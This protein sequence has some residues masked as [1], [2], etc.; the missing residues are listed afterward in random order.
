MSN[1]KQNT[2]DLQSI[3]DAVNNLPEAIDTS[4]A[5]ASA[6]EIIKNETAYVNGEKITGTIEIFDGSYECS[7]E[8]T[9]GSIS[10]VCPSLSI[11]YN[12]SK[13][14]YAAH[15]RQ[16]LYASY[17]TLSVSFGVAYGVTLR[18]QPYDILNINILNYL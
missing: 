11:N 7:G 12:S 1:I 16:L 18:S 2:T 13:F 10:S 17:D 4:D 6:N 15:I 3:L 14:K 8:N 5:T 9:G